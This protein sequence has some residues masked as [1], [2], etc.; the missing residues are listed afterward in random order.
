MFLLFSSQWRDIIFRTSTLRTFRFGLVKIS[1]VKHPTN[2]NLGKIVCIL[3]ISEQ[4]KAGT[5]NALNIKHT[6]KS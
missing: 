5:L 1:L 3:H 4:T 2:L 6:V